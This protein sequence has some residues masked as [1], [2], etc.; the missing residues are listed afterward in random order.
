[1]TLIPNEVDAFNTVAAEIDPVDFAMLAHRVK[2]NGVLSGFACT[3][4]GVDMDVDVAEGVLN[5][6]DTAVHIAAGAVTLDAADATNP[7]IDLVVATAAAALTF[8]KGTAAA[9]PSM[10]ALTTDDTVLCAVWIPATDT[11]ITTTQLAD[12]RL[13]VEGRVLIRQGADQTR[14]ST[15]TFAD[16]DD[17]QLYLGANELWRYE[18]MMLCDA[19]SNTPDIKFQFTVPA[20][21]EWTYGHEAMTSNYSSVGSGYFGAIFDFAGLGFTSNGFSGLSTSW[22]G[23]CIGFF[24]TFINGGTAGLATFQF[25]QNTSNGS[26]IYI[27]EGSIFKADRIR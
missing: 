3:G 12:K 15:T 25:A 5:I 14:T 26:P 10:P 8:R 2:G 21:C 18:M 9:A 16:H 23:K 27:R 6:N 17:F 11:A 20:G 7:R 1:M 22:N 19:D 24:G 4:A 13:H